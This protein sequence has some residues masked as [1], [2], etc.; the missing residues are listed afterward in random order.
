MLGH[1]DIVKLLTE[2]NATM[3]NDII[4]IT[5]GMGKI[6]QLLENNIINFN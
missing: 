1:Q 4:N 3:M 6:K 5:N 2:K